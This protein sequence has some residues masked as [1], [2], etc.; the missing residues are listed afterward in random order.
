MNESDLLA[1]FGASFSNHTGIA[2]YKPTIQVDY[3]AMTLGRFYSI[4]V[5]VW[6][7]I[8]VTVGE[9]FDRLPEAAD[10][11]AESQHEKLVNQLS[12]DTA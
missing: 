4:D 11:A 10:L 8:G 12:L 2:E 7:E 9:L 1:V 3:D 6:G 5:P